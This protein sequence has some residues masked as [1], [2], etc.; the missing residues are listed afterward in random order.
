VGLALAGA[1]QQ[2]TD[3][4]TGE[5][6]EQGV[7]TAWDVCGMD[8]A[9]TGLIV[10]ST[11]EAEAATGPAFQ[12]L[13][14]SFVLA[15][16]RAVVMSLW[17]PGAPAAAFLL[18]RFYENLSGKGLACHEALRQAQRA[19]RDVTVAAL[20]A[21]RPSAALKKALARQPAQARPFADPLQ[22]GAFVCYG[23]L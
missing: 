9:G 14:R 5:R 2:R 12:G 8:L 7:L 11:A 18:E 1:A 13:Q 4:A 20:R 3:D 17:R 22:W 10:L 6:S 21:A 16:A 19:T 15:G 23:G